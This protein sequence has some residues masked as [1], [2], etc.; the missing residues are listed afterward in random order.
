M[1]VSMVLASVDS[2]RIASPGR[3]VGL[4]QAVLS[5]NVR[6]FFTVY[7]GGFRPFFTDSFYEARRVMLERRR[8]LGGLH[9]SALEKKSFGKRV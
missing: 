6:G 3:F 9:R 5:K 4:K 8:Y 7:G 1:V 2:V